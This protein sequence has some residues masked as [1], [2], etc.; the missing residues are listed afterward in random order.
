[1]GFS[2]ATG[3]TLKT[4]L[5]HIRALVGRNDKYQGSTRTLS[6]ATRLHE[7]RVLRYRGCTHLTAA[8]SGRFNNLFFTLLFKGYERSPSAGRSISGGH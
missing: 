2:P 4:A 5:C 6:E 3:P 7:A 8:S 1:M